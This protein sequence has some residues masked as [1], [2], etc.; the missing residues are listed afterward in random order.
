MRRRVLTGKNAFWVYSDRCWDYIPFICILFLVLNMF[1][2]DRVSFSSLSLFYCL[3]LTFT[4]W[5]LVWL[6]TSAAESLTAWIALQSMLGSTPTTWEGWE[7]KERWRKK[8]GRWRRGNAPSEDY[9]VSE[10]LWGEVEGATSHSPQSHQ[11][12]KPVG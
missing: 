9:P 3:W 7:E 2:S 5:R 4:R 8:R 12:V 11:Q 1:P 6:H 10:R